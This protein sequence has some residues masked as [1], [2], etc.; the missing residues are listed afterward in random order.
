MRSAN[1]SVI[2]VSFGDVLSA[3]DMLGCP[4]DVPPIFLLYRVCTGS[5]DTALMIPTEQVTRAKKAP[6][7]RGQNI[8]S[9]R[10]R[11]FEICIPLY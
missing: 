10:K 5:S 6:P 9:I 4:V 2:L 8:R 1:D 3:L 11:I 7:Q